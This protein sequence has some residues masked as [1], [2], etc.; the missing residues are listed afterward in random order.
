MVVVNKDS[1]SITLVDEDTG[2]FLTLTQDLS[3]PIGVVV[4][5]FN[6]DGAPDIAVLNATGSIKIFQNTSS[7]TTIA[8]DSSLPAISLGSRCHVCGNRDCRLQQ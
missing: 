7:A 4:G 2:A 6:E 8:F 5:D 1:N 3:S